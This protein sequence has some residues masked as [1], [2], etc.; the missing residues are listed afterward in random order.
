MR[1]S[2]S[3]FVLFFQIWGLPVPVGGLLVSQVICPSLRL[4]SPRPQSTSTALNFQQQEFDNK[5]QQ[6]PPA[7][8]STPNRPE[9]ISHLETVPPTRLHRVVRSRVNDY[10]NN[11]SDGQYRYNFIKSWKTSAVSTTVWM[12]ETKPCQLRDTWYIRRVR[13]FYIT[14]VHRMVMENHPVD[15]GSI[16]GSH[17]PISFIR[18]KHRTRAN[19]ILCKTEY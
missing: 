18:I 12:V 14:S 11:W 13:K 17:R 2:Y 5:Q 19:D 4:S 8:S 1:T 9:S 10:G 15:P 16:Q 3:F 7:D 6:H